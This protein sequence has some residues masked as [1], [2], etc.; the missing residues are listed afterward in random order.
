MIAFT[1]C[2]NNYLAEALTLGDSLAANGFPAGNYRIFLADERTGE[3]DYAG[4]RYRV[5]KVNDNM[6]PGF[7][8]LTQY[9]DIIELCTSVKPS[10]FKYLLR[11][12]RSEQVF[13]YFD[14]DLY[15]FGNAERIS[16]EL[17][18]ASILLTPHV[19]RPVALQKQPFE[20]VFLNFGI[21]NL[22][23]L[24][25]RADDNARQ[26]LDW[27]EERT[28]NLGVIDVQNG[29][30]VDQLWMNL[31]PLFF[32]GVKVSPHLGFNAAH[33]N[34]N[35][36]TIKGVNGRY[37]VNNCFDLLFFHFSSFDFS[38]GRLSKRAYTSPAE[39][40]PALNE[41]AL[42]YKN[43]LTANNYHF[44]KKIK[45]AY[46]VSFDNYIAKAFPQGVNTNSISVARKFRKFPG[47]LLRKLSN[48]NYMIEIVKK[49]YSSPGN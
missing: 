14:P 47:R 35:E 39:N 22:G 28:L 13:S 34:L 7:S 24:T 17:G 45:P 1:V 32:S 36:R 48:L 41:M 15:F 30:F 27:W 6:V 18:E 21:Y 16:A 2:S 5:T 11:E 9:Y 23:F 19:T 37:T 12:N 20:N 33:W 29:Y 42:L 8:R 43:G 3:I 25:L 46:R 38:L 40:D 31:A 26:M 10:L 4:L 44:F 49:Y